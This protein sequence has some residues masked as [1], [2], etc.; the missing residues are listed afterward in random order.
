MHLVELPMESQLVP[1]DPGY[2]L[3]SLHHLELCYLPCLSL[4]TGDSFEEVILEACSLL[5]VDMIRSEDGE[6]CSSF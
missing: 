2:P 4:V 1:Q 3:D 6:Q 5:E